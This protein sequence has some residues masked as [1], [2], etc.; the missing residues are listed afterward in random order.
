MKIE[1]MGSGLYRYVKAPSF[2]RQDIGYSPGGAA[3]Q[4]SFLTGNALI[5]NESGTE[6]LE[7]VFLSAIKF[8]TPG[9]AVLTGAPL[10][11]PKI[12]T[13]DTSDIKE[14]NH[15]VTFPVN[16]G[17][18]LRPGA[19]KLYGLRTYLSFRPM[20]FSTAHKLSGRERGDYKAIASW[21]D[22]SGKIRI[23]AGPEK[24]WL[25]SGDSL[26]ASHWTVARESNAMGLRLIGTE[27]NANRS[28]RL[29][30]S[31]PVADGTVQLTPKGPIILLRDRQTVGGY[32]RI[33]SVI[34]ADIDLLAQYA[35]GKIM[36]FRETDIKEAKDSSHLRDITLRKLIIA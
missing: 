26:T 15:A 25:A 36:R 10:K 21:N 33:A 30:V 20:T 29:M 12:Y 1:V 16:E 34:S 24:S 23:I 27:L 14:L 6:S 9:V 19:E 11:E 32:P 35:P 2:G 13:S 28:I 7:F 3:D 18:I 5:G 8:T 17:D 4:F 31:S 22:P